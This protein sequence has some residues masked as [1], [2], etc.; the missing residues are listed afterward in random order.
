MSP[1]A[2]RARPAAAASGFRCPAGARARRN[3][4]PGRWPA[5]PRRE[6]RL[7]LET[8]RTRQVCTDPSLRFPLPQRPQPLN[9]SA[10]GGGGGG[11]ARLYRRGEEAGVLL[12]GPVVDT[13]EEC[14]PVCVSRARRRDEQGGGSE[15]AA[16][17]KRVDTE[18]QEA[19]GFLAPSGSGSR[20]RGTD[21][22]SSGGSSTVRQ[23]AWPKPPSR[24]RTW[25]ISIGASSEATQ[26]TAAATSSGLTLRPAGTQGRTRSET[27]LR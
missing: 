7:L 6:T 13:V 9:G 25:P 22:Y 21:R 17:E 12:G 26:A 5:L 8:L 1:A 27:S 24:W 19:R 20:W 10:G 16:R 4:S 2:G 23:A 18:R 11:L 14:V 3:S 15:R